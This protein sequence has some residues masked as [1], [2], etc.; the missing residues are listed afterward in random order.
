MKKSD[1]AEIKKTDI[2]NLEG[3]IKKAEEEIAKLTLDKVT[4]KMTNL[5]A[6]KNKRK[7]LAQMQTVLQ[8]KVVLAAF[9]AAQKEEKNA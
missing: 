4:N 1:L 6:I 7:D 9:E 3:Q 2:K 8:Q 5:K